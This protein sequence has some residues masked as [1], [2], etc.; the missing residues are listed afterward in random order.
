MGKPSPGSS[1][2]EGKKKQEL[3]E[4]PKLF[5]IRKTMKRRA[6]CP[7]YLSTIRTFISQIIRTAEKFLFREDFSGWEHQGCLASCLLIKME[8]QAWENGF[9][10]SSSLNTSVSGTKRDRRDSG[11]C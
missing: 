11:T 8:N 10:P 6:E 5:R 7:L 2:E 1:Q 4:G 9:C 3:K